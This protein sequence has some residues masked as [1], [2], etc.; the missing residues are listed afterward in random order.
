[1]SVRTGLTTS[2]RTVRRRREKGAVAAIVAVLLAGGVVMGMLAVS[3]DVGAVMQQRRSV[4]NAS[5][6]AALALAQACAAGDTNVC[7]SANAVAALSGLASANSSGATVEA[8]CASPAAV[9]AG[10]AISTPCPTG[11]TADLGACLPATAAT[12]ALWY[13]EVRTRNTVTTP[14]GEALGSAGGRVVPACARAAWGPGAPT[15]TTVVALTMSEC[16]WARQVGYPTSTS[17][18]PAPA[19]A[20]PGYSN[21]DSRPDWPSTENVVYSKGNDTTC[22]TSSPGGTAPGGFAWLEGLFTTCTG[23][24]TDS[25]WIQG[26]TGADG[27]SDALFRPFV[28]TVI[29]I[30][31]FD[32]TMS[33]DPGREPVATDSCHAGSGS[34]TYYHVSGFAAFYLSGWRL[35]KGTQASLRPPNTLCGSGSAQRCLSGWFL[36]SLIPAGQ[37]IPPTPTNPNYGVTVV[38]PA[39]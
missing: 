28:G 17:Y 31:V 14:F 38:Q 23:V 25:T 30:P 10:V 35:T 6:A 36:R 20:W 34:N 29:Y 5:D 27:C 12:S 13:V 2:L 11:R 4:Q 32:C 24:I 9:A 21:T 8:V 16:D 33:T 3:I 15:A 1:M 37:I 7:S 22:D 19:G 26:N 18:P 39:G